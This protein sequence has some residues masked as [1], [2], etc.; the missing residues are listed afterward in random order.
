MGA[1]KIVIS[2]LQ[3]LALVLQTCLPVATSALPSR[4]PRTPSSG[5]PVAPDYSRRFAEV[6]RHCQSLLSSSAEELSVEA[7][8]AGALIRHLSFTDG[9]WSQDAGQAPMFPFR[10]GYAGLNCSPRVVQGHG[11]SS[12]AARRLQRE[13]APYLH[14]HMG[15]RGRR[16]PCSV[17]WRVYRDTVVGSGERRESRWG[18]EDGTIKL[19]KIIKQCHI[20]FKLHINT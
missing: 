5:S 17:P 2:F 16:I 20:E 10:G 12:S 11:G 19:N 1:A 8:R 18:E 7:D 3:I 6:T 14:R 9:D 13:R 4:H 15:T